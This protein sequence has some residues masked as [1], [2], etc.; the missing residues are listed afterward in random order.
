[1]QLVSLRLHSLI[2]PAA[3]DGLH[4]EPPSLYERFTPQYGG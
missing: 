2:S 3:Q 1:V 4:R